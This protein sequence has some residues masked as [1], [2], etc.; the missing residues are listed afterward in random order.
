MKPRGRKPDPG[1]DARIKQA[2]V[3]LLLSKG[4]SFTVDEV[5][6]AAGVGRASVFRR[7]PTKRDLL[8][9]AC[10]LAMDAQVPTVP[11]TGSLE[12]DL[13]VIVTETL[14]AWNSPELAERTREIFGEA[15]RD[16]AVADIIRTAMR[17]RMAR[18]WAI[19]DHAIARGELSA[20]AD[21]WLLS[22]MLV[23]LAVYRGLIDVPQPDPAEMLR[24]LMHGFAR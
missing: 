2:A 14:A 17:D 23:G 13:L 6:A 16:R 9:D 1:V 4:P 21:L 3:T 11:D 12:G 7:Y 20:D 15:G 24:A 22:D 10:A 19:Y 18:S 5:A 8:L